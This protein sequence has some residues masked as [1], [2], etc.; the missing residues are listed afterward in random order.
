MDDARYGGKDP[1]SLNETI[2]VAWNSRRSLLKLG[3]T[4][5]TAPA[6]AGLAGHV[7]A[8]PSQHQAAAQDD[9][10]TQKG[11]SVALGDVQILFVDLQQALIEGSRTIP[12]QALATNAAVLAKMGKLL[13]IPMTFSVVPVA[14]QPG[15]LVPELLPFANDQNIFHR[16]PAGSF[17]DQA[18]VSA[19]ANHRR[20]TLAI[21]GY[22][23][24]VAVLQ[25]ALG[26][27]AA[28]YKVQ[29]PVDV[30]GSAS[31]RTENAAMRQMELAGAIPTTVISLAA[32][33]TPN[34]SEEP[35]SSVLSMFS[36][37]R[38]VN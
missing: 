29:I 21:A 9:I 6:L 11:F 4:L 35:G 2:P 15:T 37:L 12:A 18:M 26:A 1:G 8:A 38:T 20:R 19:L 22:A 27:V 30:T 36:E 31:S 10:L 7:L 24:E 14:G 32:F 17:S 25:S 5:L 13:N 33:L 23:T 34:F 16:K 28:G 3:A